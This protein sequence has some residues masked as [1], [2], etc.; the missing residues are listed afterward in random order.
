[1][2]SKEKYIKFCEQESIPVFSQSWWLDAVCS[3]ENWEVILIEKGEEIIASFPYYMKKKYG[4]LKGITNPF[5]TQKLGVYIKYPLSQTEDERLSLEKKIMNE[6]I[7]RLPFFDFFIVPFD[8]KYSNWLPFYWQGFKQSTGYSY[9]IE[10]I[11]DIERVF[12]NFDR[13]KKKNIR[14]SEKEVQVYF[15][16][17]CEEFYENHVMTLQKQGQAIA[18]TFSAFQQI[19]IGAYK[20]NQGKTIYCKDSSGH[21]HAALFVVW[22]TYS[23]FDL[24]STIDPSFRN[25]GAA[26]LLVY[27]MMKFLS[28]KVKVFDFEGSMIEG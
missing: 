2:T 1:M 4:F 24:I 14:K 23:A 26:S 12:A 16:L 5:M 13:S 20:H 7:E 9:C 27:E 15:D 22:D 6:I 3:P 11:S 21:I 25:S 18:Y 28:A 19:Y 10:D 8:Y 17:S